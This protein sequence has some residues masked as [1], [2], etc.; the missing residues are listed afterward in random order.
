MRA[1]LTW[2]SIDESGSPISTPPAIFARQLAWLRSGRVRVVPLTELATLDDGIS[3]VALTFDDALASVAEAALPGLIQAGL[4]A[5]IF[6]ATAHVGSDNRWHGQAAY[7]VPVFPVM[8]WE[9]LGEAQDGGIEIGAHTQTHPD[10]R[11]CGE[12]ALQRELRGASEDIERALGSPPEAF[13][14]PYGAHDQRIRN[15]A[16]EV[17]RFSVTTDLRPLGAGDTPHALPRLDAWY[18]RDPQWLQRWDTAALRGY[19]GV[20]RAGRTLRRWVS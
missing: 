12:A 19:L 15:A 3:A 8:T 4:P 18:F 13:A 5:T 6:V 11:Q 7:G 9:Q 20:R 14:Y 16:S 1:I 17:Y 2:H 10:L